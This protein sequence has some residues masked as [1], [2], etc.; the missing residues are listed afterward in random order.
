MESIILE[1]LKELVTYD[2]KT[3]IIYVKFDK[4]FKRENIKQHNSYE[5]KLRKF[6]KSIPN[7]ASGLNIVLNN[8]IE[9]AIKLLN[10]KITTIKK[11]KNKRE[12]SEEEI[13]NFD[14]EFI[15]N[16]KELYNDPKLIKIVDEYIESTY[17]ICLD[18]ISTKKINT[19]L[20]VTD[21]VNK[22]IL[23]AAL[24][25]RIIT[26][27]I[28]DYLNTAVYSSRRNLF[29]IINVDIIKLFSD[30][31]QNVLNKLE[32]I[33]SSRIYQTRYSDTVIWN[34]YKLL[35]IDINSLILEIYNSIID[36]IISKILPNESSIKFLDVVIRKKI[37]YKFQINFPISYKSLKRNNE[38]DDI[39]DKDK[40]EMVLFNSEI[41]EGTQIINLVT[42]DQICK[43]YN[44]SKSDIEEFKKNILKNNVNEI[45]KYFI[46]IYFGS[47]FDCNCCNYEQRIILLMGLIKDLKNKGFVQIVKLLEST[48]DRNSYLISKR[49][50]SNKILSS[51][52]FKK[53]NE[54]FLPYLDIFMKDNPVAKMLSFKNYKFINEDIND[55]DDSYTVEVIKFL[56]MI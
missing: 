17:T 31:K 2:D 49:K 34:Y 5:I 10:F 48:I 11:F 20:Q 3:N 51:I 53:L 12:Y 27:T 16:I 24:M 32:R 4:I 8:Y 26:P 19:D 40:M 38:D 21:K 18:D 14:K 39:D 42:I 9:F 44:F 28:C 23:K 46:E 25:I 13:N 35:S 55:F 37:Q 30:G 56:N 36:S 52:E 41:D 1:N 45:Q 22:V 15:K 47:K 54:K 50:I 33:V 43:K 6:Y 29:Y 7:I